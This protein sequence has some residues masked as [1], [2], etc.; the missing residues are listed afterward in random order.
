MQTFCDFVGDVRN[1]LTYQLSVKPMNQPPVLASRFS[2]CSKLLY[3]S[4]CERILDHDR[5]VLDSRKNYFVTACLIL[6]VPGILR[7]EHGS[8]GKHVFTA[9]AF[10]DGTYHRYRIRSEERRVGKEC[11]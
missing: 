3:L 5:H 2:I 6:F 7:V 10:G 4:P 8:R 1:W 9:H 11:R